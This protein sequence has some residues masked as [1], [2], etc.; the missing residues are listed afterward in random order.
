M[1]VA[2]GEGF[3]V[4]EAP[5]LEGWADFGGLVCVAFCGL[6][7]EDGS[8]INLISRFRRYQRLLSLRHN[9]LNFQSICYHRILRHIHLLDNR[10]N[11]FSLKQS[12][13]SLIPLLHKLLIHRHLPIKHILLLLLLQHLLCVLL[14][15][16]RRVIF[17]VRIQGRIR[18][19]NFCQLFSGRR[20]SL[21]L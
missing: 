10:S 21:F 12:K 2:L 7:L 18:L 13:L 1:P 11:I 17:I 6:V 9:L 15:Q 14:G 8:Q 19:K 4:L 20:I 5:G 3:S 16:Q